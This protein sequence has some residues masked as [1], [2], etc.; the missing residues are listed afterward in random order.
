MFRKH[1]AKIFSNESRKYL[2][3][4]GLDHEVVITFPKLY[5]AHFGYGERTSEYAK[6]QRR[7]MQ[8]ND[9]MHDAMDLFF[10]AFHRLIVE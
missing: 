4:T 5:T 2:P 10:T 3:T 7:G 6:P 1:R 9:A 8:R